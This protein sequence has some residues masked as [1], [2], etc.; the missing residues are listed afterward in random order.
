MI[1]S[2]SAKSSL[3]IVSTA[4]LVVLGSQFVGCGDPAPAPAPS[5]APAE[6]G[7]GLAGPKAGKEPLSAPSKKK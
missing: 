1:T 2:R 3:Q 7:K 6:G 4:M 5:T